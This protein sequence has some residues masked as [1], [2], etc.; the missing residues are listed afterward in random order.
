M[1]ASANSND[2]M[3]KDEEHV[4]SIPDDPLIEELAQECIKEKMEEIV[5]AADIAKSID[6]NKPEDYWKAQVLL[7]ADQA[8]KDISTDLNEHLKPDEVQTVKE[9]KVDASK[10]PKNFYEREEVSR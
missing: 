10:A 4:E 2:E 8:K 9:V 7:N 3:P 1:Q 6:D 5:R